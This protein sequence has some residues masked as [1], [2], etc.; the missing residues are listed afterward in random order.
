[1][2]VSWSDLIGRHISK[3]PA[4]VLYPKVIAETREQ[5]ETLIGIQPDHPKG[6]LQ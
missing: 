6:D 5:N 1:M 3:G 4:D 2:F